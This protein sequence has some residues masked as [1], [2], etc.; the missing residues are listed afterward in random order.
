[1]QFVFLF[2]L[3]FS[4]NL[5]AEQQESY[6][7]NTDYYL[8]STP[9]FDT[10]FHDNKIDILP[11]GSRFTVLKRIPRGENAEALQIRVTNFASSTNDLKPSSEYWIYKSNN[12]DFI[13]QNSKLETQAGA[14]CTGCANSAQTQTHNTNHIA[15]VL[16]EVNKN[17]NTV[18]GPLDEQIKKYSESDEVNYTIYSAMRNKKSRSQGYCYRSVKKALLASPKN[19]KG[20]IPYHYSDLPALNAKESLKKFGFVNLLEIE[21]YKTQM[22]SPSQAPK[23]AVLV[24]SSGIPCDSGRVLDCGHTEIKTNNPGKPG[25]V[26]DYYSA[27]AIN[28]T[29]GAR[30]YG[31]R[32]K[33]VGVMIKP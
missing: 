32:Y 31:T 6:R 20:L 14:T 27:D 29:A 26:S 5:F 4:V 33:L 24:F 17:E 18:S 21:P 19:K 16:R 9:N 2:V 10:S 15:D 28:E 3:S 1:M 22:K 23:G 25:Y 30:R 8:R 11:R 12:T 13:K 7:L